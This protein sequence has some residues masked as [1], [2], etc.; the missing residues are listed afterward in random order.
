[1]ALDGAYL[2]LLIRE[3]RAVGL[4]SRI[5]KI[6]QPSKEE[7]L[8]TLRSRAGTRRLLC[9]ANAGSPRLHFTETSPES[10]QTPPMFCILLRKH[11]GSGRLV[12]IRQQGMDRTVFF[13]F[14]ATNELHDPVRMTLAA[15]LMGRHSNLILIGP[16]GK[17]IDA[18]KRVSPSQS[19]VRL[20]QPGF[21]YQLP[22]A[23]DKCNL[24]T[25]EWETVRERLA[26]CP[27][28]DPCKALL[29]TFEGMSPL[30]MRELLYR[31]FGN[32][33]PPKDSWQEP[34]TSAVL[35]GLQTL[36]DT[37]NGSRPPCYT[38]VTDQA[39]G[40]REF[41]F[42]DIT[43]Y[44]DVSKK[45]FESPS[46]LLDVFYAERDRTDRMKQRSHD[47]LRLL[48]A[49]TDRIR[50]KLLLQEEELRTCAD[51]DVLKTYGDLLSANLYRLQ[52]GDRTVL[53]ENFYEPELPTVEIALDPRLTPA[54]NAQHYYALY[55]KAATAEEKLQ[56]LMAA[57]R[58]ELEYLDSVYDAVSRTDGEQELQE[59][60]EELAAQGYLRPTARKGSRHKPLPPLRYRTDDGFSVLCGRNNLQN[61]QLT[62]RY[63]KGQDLWL[64]TQGIAGS[65]V[66]LEGDGRD[67]SDLAITQAAMIAAYHS[68]GRAS[69]QV[70]V[71]YTLVRYVKKPYG[72]RPGKV[73]FTNYFTAYVTPE[74]ETVKRLA[75]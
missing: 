66:I 55:R 40:L 13:D 48:T 9:C 11:L 10:P 15:E 46:A 18:I 25:A 67:F 24:A 75:L 16:D 57:S 73:I 17:I 39:L 6:T 41:A 61:D 12:E 35:A 3:L 68:K 56:T 49:T 63:A 65:H 8:I 59:I 14:E 27:Q 31:V 54:Q 33:V 43:Q 2:S 58:S 42:T 5:E 70:A 50:R 34:Q 52:K 4:G 72:A 21:T 26:A 45:V 71:D 51:R 60:R 28:A 53:L 23:Q 36:R 74:E 20:V 38:L 30:V 37:L 22:P 44:G 62:L 7:I 1:M 29:Q 69:S 32:S 19:S 47:L 64:H